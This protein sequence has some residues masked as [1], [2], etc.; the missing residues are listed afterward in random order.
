MKKIIPTY[1]FWVFISSCNVNS[2]ELEI[3]E[4]A[5]EHISHNDYD[6][7]K[8]LCDNNL[9][10]ND[11]YLNNQ[12]NRAI[13]LIDSC[14]IPSKNEIVLIDDNIY[15]NKDMIKLKYLFKNC[16]KDSEGLSKISPYIIFSFD[17][18]K[19]DAPILNIYVSLNGE[20]LSI[21]PTIHPNQ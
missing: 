7:F 2:N 10:N 11:Q 3:V 4:T 14:G 5:I 17:R 8:H 15:K 20:P 6:E 19:R 12:F 13:K 16:S 9:S 21:K 18:S 1:L